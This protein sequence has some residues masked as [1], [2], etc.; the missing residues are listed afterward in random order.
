NLVHRAKGGASPGRERETG[1]D[2]PPPGAP[3]FDLEADRAPVGTAYPASSRASLLRAAQQ[4]AI[5][6]RWLCHTLSRARLRSPTGGLGGHRHHP[7]GLSLRRHLRADDDG[8][9]AGRGN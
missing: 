4:L 3:A 9:S 8:G 2:P 5:L 7:P 1:E 6:L